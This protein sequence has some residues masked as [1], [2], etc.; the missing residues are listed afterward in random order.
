M[1]VAVLGNGRISESPSSGVAVLRLVLW[2]AVL[3][4]G[5]ELTKPAVDLMLSRSVVP[6]LDPFL[7]MASCCRLVKACAEDLRTADCLVDIWY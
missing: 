3:S 2:E 6:L 4:L 5:R 1:A 7:A